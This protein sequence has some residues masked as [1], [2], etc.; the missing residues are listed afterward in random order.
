MLASPGLSGQLLSYTID[1]KTA[2]NQPDA[3]AL[4]ENAI[5]LLKLPKI[6]KYFFEIFQK[7]TTNQKLQI[8]GAS[9]QRIAGPGGP[10]GPIGGGGQGRRVG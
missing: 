5:N 1:L 2:K 7:N 9:K 10:I 8:R 6:S 3:T 4:T